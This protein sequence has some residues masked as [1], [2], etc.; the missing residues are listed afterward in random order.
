[1]TELERMIQE[2]E[3]L[4]EDTRKLVLKGWERKSRLQEAE[5]YLEGLKRL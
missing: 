5:E 1:M 2:A 4:V 3:K